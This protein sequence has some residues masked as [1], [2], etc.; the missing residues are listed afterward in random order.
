MLNWRMSFVRSSFLKLSDWMFELELHCQVC[1]ICFNI[2]AL[3]DI[4]LKYRRTRWDCCLVTSPTWR[5]GARSRRR[6]PRSLRG[7]T[8]WSS[9][10]PRLWCH[11][12]SSMP[13]RSSHLRSS[14]NPSS[15]SLRPRAAGL[16]TPASSRFSVVTNSKIRLVFG[17]WTNMNIEYH[18]LVIPT[19]IL[20]HKWTSIWSQ[21]FE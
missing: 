4:I 5:P 10:R 14:P 7:H 12:R 20:A 6:R 2:I 15:A 21:L 17:K 19:L 16:Q 11:T 8:T 1:V 9:W 13:S 3:D 18:Y